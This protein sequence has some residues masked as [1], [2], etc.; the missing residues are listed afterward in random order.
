M[1]M[2]T[3]TV[4]NVNE[5]LKSATATISDIAVRHDLSTTTVMSLF[6]KFINI[7]RLTLPRVLCIDEVYA[8]KSDISKYVCVL[9]DFVEHTT[10]D[11]LETRKK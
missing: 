11:L 2:S 3:L 9:V 5:D 10:I 8:F 1:K 7:S 6:D 4:Y